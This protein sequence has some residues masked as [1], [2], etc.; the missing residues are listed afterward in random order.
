VHTGRNLDAPVLQLTPF[1]LRVGNDRLGGPRGLGQIPVCLSLRELGAPPALQRQP[2]H[3]YLELA[4]TRLIAIEDS[5]RERPEDRKP[6]S[7]RERHPIDCEI[8]GCRE[9]ARACARLQ[10]HLTGLLDPGGPAASQT[11]GEGPAPRSRG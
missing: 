5:Q 4:V 7:P 10:H 9:P 2:E 1:Q 8:L 3:A 6:S 11:G